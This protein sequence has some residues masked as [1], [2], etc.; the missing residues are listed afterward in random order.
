MASFRINYLF[1]IFHIFSIVSILSLNNGANAARILPNILLFESLP[2]GPVPPS[3]G[4]SCTYIPGQ[5]G[6]PCPLNEKHF[7]GRLCGGSAHAPPTTDVI[8]SLRNDEVWK[9]G[10]SS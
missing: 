8:A 6:P 3:G 5:G 1:L 9:K 10:S 2:R 4:S 7:A